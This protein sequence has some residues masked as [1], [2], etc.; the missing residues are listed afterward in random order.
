MILK[1]FNA[2][3]LLSFLTTLTTR[4]AVAVAQ[5]SDNLSP[6]KLRSLGESALMERDYSAATS[7][8][9]QAI[10]LEP[11]NAVNHYKLYNVHKRQRMLVEALEDIT[12]A[13][14]VELSSD[15]VVKNGNTKKLIEY[16]AQ[17]AKLLV[18]LGRC[19]E[20]LL[21][22]EAMNVTSDDTSFAAAEQ[23]ALAIETAA[24][25]IDTQD[26]NTAAHSL[27]EVISHLSTPS[28][29]PDL[30]YQLAQSQY[31]IQDYYGCISDTGRLLKAYP[32]HLEAYALRGEAYWKLNEVEMA[33]KHFREG[34]KLDPEHGGELR[35]RYMHSFCCYWWIEL[36]DVISTLVLILL[37]QEI[38]SNWY[39]NYFT[40]DA[41]RDIGK[42]K[43]SPKRTKREMSIMKKAITNKP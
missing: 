24:D 26:W 3:V 18:G 11:D 17:K 31:H 34:L 8:Y 19:D 42:W 15:N 2:L 20:A 9:R 38:V 21:E 39:N 13:V 40:Q 35:V 32:Q 1:P 27:K 41:K 10:E 7:Y 37:T 25:A 14:S 43:K 5:S 28:D 12:N 4:P 29:A 33:G 22:Y 23:C 30:L 36:M 16:R 6:G